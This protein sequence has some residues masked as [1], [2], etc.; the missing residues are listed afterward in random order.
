MVFYTLW[1]EL[2][3]YS[4]GAAAA[5][6]AAFS[7]GTCFGALIGGYL[8]DFMARKLPNTGMPWIRTT[9]TAANWSGLL[10]LED[11]GES[12]FNGSRLKQ[13]PC[14]HLEDK[15]HLPRLALE[16]RNPR[17]RRC[18]PMFRANR[19]I[20]CDVPRHSCAKRKRRSP[21]VHACE[22]S[23]FARPFGPFLTDAT[24]LVRPPLI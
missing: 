23:H 7:V 14:L 11:E 5:L 19:P 2:V 13:T 12:C 3:G 21:L 24:H 22:P 4:H 6:V 9:R 18:S 16:R 8:G 20:A 17:A 10:G 1:L 15:Q